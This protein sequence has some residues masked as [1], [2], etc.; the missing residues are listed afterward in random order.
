MG[1]R[2]IKGFYMWKGILTALQAI[3]KWLLFKYRVENK[4]DGI[5][6]GLEDNNR[7][8]LRLEI[9]EAMRR[10]DRGTVYT[11]YDE[12]KVRYHGNSYMDALFKDFCKKGAKK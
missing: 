6:R 7:R 1:K 3:W 2:I 8:I 11:L 5:T 4:I 12:Y 9:L 10:K